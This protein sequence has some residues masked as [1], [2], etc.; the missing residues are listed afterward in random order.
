[1]SFSSYNKK[2][3]Y[4]FYA[5][6]RKEVVHLNDLYGKIGTTD[7]NSPFHHGFAIQL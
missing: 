2:K 4:F 7:Q 5:C 1:M 3:L 6:F